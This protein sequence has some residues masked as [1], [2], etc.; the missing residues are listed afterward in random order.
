MVDWKG[1]MLN[2]PRTK[3]E[4]PIPVPLNDDAV[5]AVRVAHDRGDERGRVF[6]PEKKG[7][8]RKNSRY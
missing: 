3:N 1:R 7:E 8:P 5:A 2:I 4:E 6:Q